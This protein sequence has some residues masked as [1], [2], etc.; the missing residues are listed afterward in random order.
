[1]KKKILVTGS[2]GFLGSHLKQVLNFSKKYECFFTNRNEFDLLELNQF[3]QMLDKYTPDVLIHLAAYSGGIGANKKYPA[4]FYF[5]NSLLTTNAFQACNEKKIKKII[6]PMGGCSYPATSVSPINEEKIWDGYPQQESAGYSM[7]KKMSIVAAKSYKDQYGLN[8]T[9]IIPGNMYG[10]YDNF[11]HEE[12]H[13]IPSLI[14][15]FYE[16]KKNNDNDVILWGDGSP[17]R[18]FIY[19]RDVAEIL[20][21]FIDNDIEGPINISSGEG[22]SIR[23]LSSLIA[24]SMGYTGGIVWDTSKPNGQK[25]KIF[26]ISFLKKL[27]YLP[28]TDLQLGI[29]N[30]ISWF[31]KSYESNKEIRL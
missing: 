5:Q 15:K 29:K 6:Y 18:D 13:V 7:A 30:T 8:S 4:D 2:D 19:A 31:E 23:Q 1:M 28:K 17:I 3:N 20:L 10:E 9:I 22:I 27:K 12:S 16:A 26:D 25:I 24:K 21:N 14:R 11:R